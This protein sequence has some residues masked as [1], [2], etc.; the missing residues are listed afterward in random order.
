M[1]KPAGFKCG[2]FGISPSNQQLLAIGDFSGNLLIVDLEKE[3]VSFQTTAHKEI[4]NC[5]DGVGG[6]DVGHGAAE[7]VTGGRDGIIV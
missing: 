5:I 4:V 1:E 2:T 6:L 7:L 3:A